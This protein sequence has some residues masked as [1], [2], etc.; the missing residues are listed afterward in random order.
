M[1]TLLHRKFCN[2]LMLEKITITLFTIILFS[3]S[4][5][6]AQKKHSLGAFVLT[7]EDY[8]K[9]PKANWDTLTKYSPKLA[10]PE[11]TIESPLTGISPMV[12]GKTVMLSHTPPIGNQGGEASCVGWGVGYT[13]MGILVYPKYNYWDIISERSPAYIF[14]QIKLS[15]LRSSC[16]TGSYVTDALNLVTGK[17]SWKVGDC[18]WY[19]MPYVDGTCSSLPNSSQIYD[20]SAN[21]GSNWYALTVTDT[22]GIK[23]ALRLGYPVPISQPVYDSFYNMWYSNGIVTVNSGYFWG[24]HCTCIVG[25]NDGTQMFKVQNQWGTASGDCGDPNNPG[26]Y[27]IPYTMILNSFLNEAY[28]LY[29]I[30]PGYPETI[31]G[32]T[33]VCTSGTY[34]VSNIPSGYTV[35]WTNGSN[36]TLQSASGNSAVFLENGNGASWVKATLN[37]PAGSFN[38]PQYSVWVGVFSSTVVTGTAAVCPNSLYTYT[39]QVPG[40]HKSNYSYSWTYPSGWYNNGQVQNM[41]NLQTPMYNMTYG[42]V[43]V[44]VTNQCG[45]SGYSGGLTVYPGSCPH[46]FTIYPNPASNNI[47]ITMIDNSTYSTDADTVIANVNSNISTSDVPINFTIRIYNSQ[48]SLISSVKRSGTSFSVPLA[49][50]RDG[51]YIVEVNDGKTSTTQTLIV[52]HN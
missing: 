25:Y 1:K 2:L 49:N 16:D 17:G 5:L 21:L 47:T 8:A 23:K 11:M 31:S 6:F 28:V 30:T 43:R 14:N 33:V 13:A 10:H 32:P 40:G 27:W 26:F 3:Q 39:A 20:A 22:S 46:Y 4:D 29:G 37:G 35:S 24:W 44:A 34:S 50:M 52:K 45:T 38:L 12:S 51:T 41:I 19:S 48:G 42:V 36:L 7:P 9:L 18:C 15:K